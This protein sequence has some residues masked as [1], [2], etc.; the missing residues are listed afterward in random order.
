MTDEIYDVIVIGGGP[1]GLSAAQYASRAKLRTVVLDKSPSA[2]ALALSGRI[3]IPRL[4]EP[5]TGKH[6]LDISAIRPPGSGL[7][8]SK[9][10][11]RRQSEQ[12]TKRSTRWTRHIPQNGNHR[13]RFNGRSAESREKTGQRRM[14]CAICDA[15]IFSE[16]TVCVVGDTGEALRRRQLCRLRLSI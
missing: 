16:Q 1:A 6:L 14:L 8:M 13:H 12:D 11:H 5:V 10:S 2:G 7:N 9:Q 3:E 4:P 15:A